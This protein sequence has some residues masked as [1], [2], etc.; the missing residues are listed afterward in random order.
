MILSLIELIALPGKREQILELLRFSADRVRTKLG[1]LGSG[2]Y[3][4]GAENQIILYF[5]RWES[6]E[7][8]CRHIRSSRYLG[9]LNA[10][11]LAKG[12][13]E[14]TFHKVEST[15][16]MELIAAVRNPDVA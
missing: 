10:I 14:V 13:P 6:E 15:M 7:E 8:L 2:V 1:C 16:S 4:S 9:I 3:E 12:P 5:E 11:D